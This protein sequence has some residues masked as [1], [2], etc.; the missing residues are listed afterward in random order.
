[1]L[2]Y[3]QKEWNSVFWK[4]RQSREV[5]PN[6]RRFFP[7]KISILFDYSPRISEIVVRMLCRSEIQRVRFFLEILK[8][9]HFR[10]FRSLNRLVC[11]TTCVL[12]Q[13]AHQCI[14]SADPNVRLLRGSLLR[15]ENRRRHSRAQTA[16]AARG[17][18]N[19]PA[20]CKS[21]YR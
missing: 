5:Y 2:K 1:M 21:C 4:F 16:G 12:Y 8:L 14:F 7:Q 17:W 10:K 15:K 3:D 11:Y 19:T 6:F 13:I 9:P 20:W 18:R